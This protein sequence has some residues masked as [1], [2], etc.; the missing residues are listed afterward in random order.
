MRGRRGDALRAASKR[1]GRLRYDSHSRR[2]AWPHAVATT[3]KGILPA[4]AKQLNRFLSS[5]DAAFLY[6][7]KPTETMHI[8]GTMIYEGRITGE[9]L[10]QLLLDCLPEI[11]RYR[12]RVVFPPLGFSHPLW[13]DDPD[14][15]ISRHVDEVHLEG[16]G[17]ER[18]LAETAIAAYQGAL[19]RDRPLWHATLIHGLPSGDTA[20]VWKIHHAMIDGVSGVDL[21]MAMNDLTPEREPRPPAPPWDPQPLPDAIT[22][23]QESA[24]HRLT[25]LAEAWTSG[26][27]SLLRPQRMADQGRRLLDALATTLPTTLRPAPKTP[28][29]APLS[30]R[31]GYAWADFS[32]TE[33]RQIKSELGGTLN[34][35]V[36]TILAGGLARYCEEIGFDVGDQTLRAMCPVSM[37]AASEHGQLGNLVSVMIAPL[38]VGERDP[39]ARHA[40]VRSGMDNLKEVGQAE[41]LFD[42]SKASQRI[43]PLLQAF[44]S[45][46]PFRQTVLN[47]V[48]TNVPGPQIPLYQGGRKLLRWLPMGIISNH[49]GLFVAILSYNRRIVI[50]LTVDRE[51]VSDPWQVV[52]CLYASQR[53][54]REAAGVPEVDEAGLEHLD[55]KG[56]LRMAANGG[57]DPPSTEAASGGPTRG[58]D[59][60]AGGGREASAKVKAKARVTAGGS[61]A[62]KKRKAKAGKKKT[63]KKSAAKK[64]AAKKKAAKKKAQKGSSKKATKKS[65]KK[66]TAKNKA[67]KKSA[68][69]DSASRKEKAADSASGGGDASTKSVA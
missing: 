30:G 20:I 3:G 52:Q 5:I 11:P 16:D 44:A 33:L 50:G 39:V 56:Q 69:A 18:D 53:E 49:I 59:S 61:S 57:S 42:L 12:Q 45:R 40:L 1:D 10:E 14:F 58:G 43:P 36:L 23:A 28:F 35:L 27:F 41:A 19:P 32:F 13:C 67:A 7:E 60:S 66:K 2:I 47:T 68:T 29:N 63:A 31:L 64:S 38:P 54:I 22:L 9:E 62:E 34:D 25:E 21:T 46:L 15:D 26:L 24:Q 6:M 65:A 17:S 48:S 4:M 8:G 51:L 55:L 37:R